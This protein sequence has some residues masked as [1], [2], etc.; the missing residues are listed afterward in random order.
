M[1]L[2]FLIFVFLQILR[3]HTLSP[4]CNSNSTNYII[5]PGRSQSGQIILEKSVDSWS[6]CARY[7][8]ALPNCSFYNVSPDKKGAHFCQLYAT[9]KLKLSIYP[10]S[11]TARKFCLTEENYKLCSRRNFA[12]E[13]FAGRAIS[14]SSWILK[15]FEVSLEDCLN[16]CIETENCRASLF[17]LETS[18]CQISKISPNSVYNPRTFF[19][20]SKNIDLY[21]NNC[22]DFEM[23][24]TGCSFM[25]VQKGGLPELSDQI[26]Q[27]IQSTDDCEQMCLIR[28][29]IADPCRSYT[30]DRSSKQCFLFYAST[31][32][33]G[34]SPL[35]N[36]KDNLSHG[37]LDDCMNFSL[38]CREHGLEVRAST[39]RLF[40]GKVMTKTKKCADFINGNYE[41]SSKFNFKECGIEPI[42]TAEMYKGMIHVKEGS[43]NLVTIR[44]KMLAVNCRMHKMPMLTEEQTLSVQ[45]NIKPKNETIKLTKDVPKFS[46]KI[47]TDNSTEASE[48]K[49]GDSG[50][51]VLTVKN[52][53]DDFTVTNLI[54]K[55]VNNKSSKTMKI[56]DEEG[57]VIRRDIITEIEKI[58]KSQIKFRINFS[59]FSKQT[60]IVYHTMIETCEIGCMPKCNSDILM[61]KSEGFINKLSLD[62]PRKH[63]MVRRA[64]ETTT[65]K[66]ELTNDLYE[67]SA[68]R[69]TLLNP[70]QNDDGVSMV[71]KV[72]TL[73]S[74]FHH[75]F[76]E[77]ITCLFTM[78]LASIQIFLLVSCLLIVW[79]YFQQW[80]Q[81]RELEPEMP[82]QQ[83]QSVKT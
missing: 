1:L 3:T 64:I 19:K 33:V 2:G 21:E 6:Q 17:N 18:M 7:C 4:L 15:T 79:C 40:V 31:R 49:I 38:K 52:S 76:I 13:K 53:A 83:I 46:L 48:V 62:L 77:D 29:K 14:N 30:Y 66:L 36:M 75:C 23:S 58:G 35:E 39:M 41:F 74:S 5:E 9:S 71:Q 63:R 43:T 11:T 69:L 10:E 73:E 54:A 56:I 42:K 26:V 47:L 72:A 81:F 28:S 80:R 82:P 32:I 27:K 25:R 16:K 68:H 61:R 37:D 24:S 51:I 57:C 50:W 60:E 20:F 67:I 34:R 22:A 70:A 55:E 44:D 45:M 65:T 59:G 78:I 12:F 8:N